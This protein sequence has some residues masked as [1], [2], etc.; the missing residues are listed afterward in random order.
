[1]ADDGADVPVVDARE[2]PGGDDGRADRAERDGRG[3]GQQH[4]DGC[5]HRRE[6]GGHEHDARDGDRCAEAGERFEQSAEAERDDDGLDARVVGEGVDHAPE[7]LEAAAAHRQLIEPDRIEHDPHDREQPEDETLRGRQ[8]CEVD[9]HPE[10]EHRDQDGDRE[11]GQSRPV[12]LPAQ[13]AE[14]E[15]HREEREAG[16]ESGEREAPADR[17]E[18][19]CVHLCLFSYVVVRRAE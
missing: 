3:V 5:A 9:R 17:G 8:E 10:T 6:A 11:S 15:E 13:H 18:F 12:R 16:H 4:D 7:V 2:G 19:G 1:M 14:R